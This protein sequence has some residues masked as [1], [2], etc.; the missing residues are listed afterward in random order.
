MGQGVYLYGKVK[1]VILGAVAKATACNH[2]CGEGHRMK[3]REVIGI[4]P[5]VRRSTPE[6]GEVL[7]KGDGGPLP[8][9][10]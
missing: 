8:E 10:L 3:V 4:R 1:G 5:E 2:F 9:L 7:R 6:Q